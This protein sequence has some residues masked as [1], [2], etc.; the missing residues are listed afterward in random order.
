MNPSLSCLYSKN[1]GSPQI[2]FIQL[3]QKHKKNIKQKINKEYVH[4]SAS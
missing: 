4:A 3:K 2:I 1:N